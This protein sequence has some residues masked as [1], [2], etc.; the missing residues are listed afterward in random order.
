MTPEDIEKLNSV[1][2]G[3]LQ[4][5]SDR[6]GEGLGLGLSICRGIADNHCASLRFEAAGLGVRATVEMDLFRD[7]DS[8]ESSSGSK[9]TEGRTGRDL[10]EK[11]KG[12]T[13][14]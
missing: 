11:T 13:P 4:D 14:K 6:Q 9:E 1:T 2:A 8:T 7:D 12:D 5:R 10:E 3:L